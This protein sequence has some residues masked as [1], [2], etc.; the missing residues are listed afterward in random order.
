M[1][2]YRSTFRSGAHAGRTNVEVVG[3]QVHGGKF[4]CKITVHPDDTFGQYNQDRVDIKH[5]STLTGEGK[6]SYLSGYY[7]LPE[8]AKTRNEIAFY[9]T[10]GTSRN[11]MDLWVEPKTGG[12]TTVKF[13][14]ESNGANLGSVLVWTGDWKAG[15]WHQFAIHVH[16]STDATKGVVDLWFDG[17]PVV[18]GYKHKTKFD[19]ND[20][21]YETGLH[22]VLPKAFVETIYFDDFI[23][24]DTLAEIMVGAPMPGGTPDGGAT[25]AE[26]NDAA[27]PAP[28]G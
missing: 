14:I 13:G 24:A 1:L 21:F 7:Y 12:G 15:Q 3:E 6:D 16:W 2:T 28:A 5:E 26:N 8:D 19:G 11:W 4:A 18:T 25:D 22:R 10:K 9:E 23:E 20:M 27:G 17:Q